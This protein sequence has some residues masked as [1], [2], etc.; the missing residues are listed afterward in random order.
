MPISPFSTEFWKATMVAGII[1]PLPKPSG[2]PM[3]ISCQSDGEGRIDV[4]ITSPATT[5]VAQMKGGFLTPIFEI[6]EPARRI[7][8]GSGKQKQAVAYGP[9]PPARPRDG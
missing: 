6:A 3:T 4:R 2:I 8:P 9:A 5:I 7:Q 1:I